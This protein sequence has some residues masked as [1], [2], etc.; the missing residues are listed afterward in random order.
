MGNRAGFMSRPECRGS[1]AGGETR[2][3]AG[4]AG[5]RPLSSGLG[6]NGWGWNA[7]FGA[8]LESAGHFH[9]EAERLKAE[10]QEAGPSLG[11]QPPLAEVRVEM[12]ILVCVWLGAGREAGGQA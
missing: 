6:C 2:G 8:R 12:G 11:V 1:A 4:G 7:I 5:S 3:S 10:M 9:P